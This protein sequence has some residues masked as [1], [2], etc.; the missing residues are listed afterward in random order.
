MGWIALCLAG[1][2]L[3]GGAAVAADQLAGQPIGLPSEPLPEG[4]QL[5]PAVAAPVRTATQPQRAERRPERTRKRRRATTT[6]PATRTATTP[7]AAPAP[8]TDD[9]GADDDRGGGRGRGDEDD[10]GGDDD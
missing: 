3:A 10:R 6:T 8:V 1:L 7:P 2:V 4:E 9:S 5:A